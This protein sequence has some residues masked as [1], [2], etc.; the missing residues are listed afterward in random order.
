MKRTY[1]ALFLVLTLTLL[2]AGFLGAQEV[3]FTGTWEAFKVVD[4][5][6]VAIRDYQ[7][8]NHP[9]QIM[10]GTFTL[11]ADGTLTSTFL[12]F[13]RWRYE[14]GFVVFAGDGMENSFYVPRLMSQDVLFFVSVIVTER[15]RE[16]THI[17]V[18]RTDN[19][20]LMRE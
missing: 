13:N 8:I 1:T 15:N 3:D 10:E 14:D 7:N 17:R 16:V 6:S 18:N 2:S 19:L 5:N 20:L 12:D 4:L 11:E 9:R